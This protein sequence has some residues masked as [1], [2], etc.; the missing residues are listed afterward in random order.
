MRGAAIV[1]ALLCCLAPTQIAGQGIERRLVT[2]A[3]APDY[4]GVG[5]LNV[6]GRRFCT[7][8]LISETLAIT[9]AHC[10]YHPRSRRPVPLSELRFVAGWRSDEYAALR[11]V[12]RVAVPEDFIFDGAPSF[13]NLRR[14]IALIEMDAP[15]PAAEAAAFPTTEAP[16]GDVPI[17]I[18]S[19]ARDRAHAASIQEA[20]RLEA[21]I[22]NV[23]ALDCGVNFGASG[24]PVMVDEKGGLRLFGVVSATGHTVADGAEVTLSVLVARELSELEARLA[25][26]VPDPDDGEGGPPPTP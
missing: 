25:G 14:D 23:A 10:L 21:L 1:S 16:V 3:E 19:Y 4:F 5:R 26:A 17:V 13:A 18:V 24:G 15:V 22:D 6:A 20:C 8:T 9:A 12:A 11:G 2:D 7:A